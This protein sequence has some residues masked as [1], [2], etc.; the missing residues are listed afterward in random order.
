MP[1]TRLQF[2]HIMTTEPTKTDYKSTLCLPQTAFPMRAN[3]NQREPEI[4][5]RWNEQGLGGKIA[6]K[7]RQH[8]SALKFITP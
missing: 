3:L 7:D 8:P 5:A 2:A 1:I 4:L 6:A